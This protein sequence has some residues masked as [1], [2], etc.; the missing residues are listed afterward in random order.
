M[1]YDG[2]GSLIEVVL[3]ADDFRAYL[4]SL[5]AEVDWETLPGFLQDAIDV[6]LID[7]VRDQRKDA[8]R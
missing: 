4:S 2:T 3:S 1:V 6:M 8:Y 5:A 7:E